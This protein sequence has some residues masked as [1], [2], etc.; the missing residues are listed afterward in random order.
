MYMEEIDA[1]KRFKGKQTPSSVELDEI[2]YDTVQEGSQVLDFGC[3]WG[4][5]AF[6]LQENGYRV[7]GFDV[8]KNA[9]REAVKLA[10]SSKKKH[11]SMVKFD[12]ADA[13]N[14]HYKDETF[15]S[16]IIQAFMTTIIK[17]EERR[18]V[19]KEAHRVLKQNG[20]LYLADFG[21]NWENSR[22][23][24][25]YHRDYPKTGE[26]GT[27]IVTDTDTEDGEEMFLAHH[28][29]RNELIK[30]VEEKFMVKTFK[31]TV[32]TTFHGNRTKG[33]IVIGEKS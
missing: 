2:F 22:Y 16:C 21:Q 8:N 19:I 29:T 18:K 12:S 26:M 27:F 7:T 28:Y 17:P 14:L 25:M 9:V 1:W 30:L 11:T 32:F 5:I 13:T 33:Y 24:E 6:Q 4:R 31:E 20:I 15:D 23:K 3:A 10:S